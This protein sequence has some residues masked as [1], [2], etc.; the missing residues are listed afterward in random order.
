MKPVPLRSQPAPACTASCADTARGRGASK[1]RAGRPIFL[2][3]AE[4]WHLLSL[5]AP[6]VSVILAVALARVFKIDLPGSTLAILF[7]GTWLLYVS[8]RILDGLR[9]GSAEHD[10]RLRERHRFYIRHRNAVLMVA[11]PVAALVAWM[12]FTCMSP[13]ARMADAMIFAVAC[14]YFSVVHLRGPAVEE[15]FP[16]EMIVALVFAAATA[17]PAGARLKHHGSLMVLAALFAALCWLN[18][19][20]IEK[21]ESS[22]STPGGGDRT[23]QWGQRNLRMVSA[24]ITGAALLASGLFLC[25]YNISAATLC[26]AMALSADMF[27]VLDRSTMSTFHLRIAA[28]AVL[29]TPLLLLFAR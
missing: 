22:P 25:T 10:S 21:W 19:V 1:E 8:D 11:V 27:F 9:A 3:P 12:V 6:S 16:K 24:A 28:D 17:V 7:A 18:C 5:D 20:A 13:A 29:L 14:V 2:T 4:Y 26:I 15:I 23:A